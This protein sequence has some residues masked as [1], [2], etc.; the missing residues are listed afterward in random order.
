MTYGFALSQQLELFFYALG[1]GFLLGILY[2]LVMTVREEISDKKAAVVAGDIIFSILATV[3]VFC[4]LLI[5]ADGQVRLIALF[6]DAVGFTLYIFTLDL[7]IKR[8]LHY[9][10]RLIISLLKLIFKPFFV[11]VRALVRFTVKTKEKIRKKKQEK[12]KTKK[13]ADKTE[14]KRN[15]RK[16][17]RKEK[18]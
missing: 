15:K 7:V 9:P 18:V 17:K 3:F 5:Y 4:F 14:N 10:I 12:V 1:F 6:A 11:F 13:T 2:R 8:L 16:K